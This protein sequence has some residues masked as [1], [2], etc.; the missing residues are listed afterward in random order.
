MGAGWSQ[1]WH[2]SSSRGGTGRINALKICTGSGCCWPSTGAYTHPSGVAWTPC[3]SSVSLVR[4]CRVKTQRRQKNWSYLS[5]MISF[6]QRCFVGD[7]FSVRI[8][9]LSHPHNLCY[10]REFCLFQRSSPHTGLKRVQKEHL[11]LC[12]NLTHLCSLMRTGPFLLFSPSHQLPQ[13]PAS[14]VENLLFRSLLVYFSE[15]ELLP[16]F[17]GEI[18]GESSTASFVLPSFF[19]FFKI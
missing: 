5:E 18:H 8:L 10:T 1:D 3:C 16:D 2:S 14:F 11:P 19:S 12:K 7:F 13:L 15:L 6:S 4:L 9:T 17:L